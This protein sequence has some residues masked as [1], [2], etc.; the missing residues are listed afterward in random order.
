MLMLARYRLAQEG[1]AVD[2]PPE[3][4]E[5]PAL[6][7][8]ETFLVHVPSQISSYQNTFN[9][10]W[11]LLQLTRHCNLPH[12]C[13]FLSVDLKFNRYFYQHNK[14]HVWVDPGELQPLLDRVN[15][16]LRNDNNEFVAG[17]NDA[18]ITGRRQPVF[19]DPLDNSDSLET[20]SSLIGQFTHEPSVARIVHHRKARTRDL[21]FNFIT[22]AYRDVRD[23]RDRVKR[24]LRDSGIKDF[25]SKLPVI[26]AFLPNCSAISPSHFKY[27]QRHIECV[28]NRFNPG[29][30]S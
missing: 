24:G 1:L 30:L 14:E 19:G 9:H 8:S 20:V 26:L 5:E 21:Q 6:F 11:H 16:T 3:I 4:L 22:N 13:S 2:S 10:P 18:V 28:S 25:S 17:S 29:L 12:Q 7:P 15:L 27:M 23:F